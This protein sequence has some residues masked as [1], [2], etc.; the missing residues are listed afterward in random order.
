LGSAIPVTV[1]ERGGARL[2]TVTIGLSSVAPGEY[3]LEITP[4]DKAADGKVY[5][6]FRVVP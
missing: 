1:T 3:V 5:A 4:S 6:A 2:A